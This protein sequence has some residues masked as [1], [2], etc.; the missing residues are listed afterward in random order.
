MPRGP[1]L[2]A[3]GVLH[4]VIARG[5]ERRAIFEDD[6]DRN[7][8][9]DRL[10]SIV[11]D[12][13]LLVYAWALMPNHFHL[14]VRTGSRPLERSM[15]ALLSGYATRFN[16]RHDRAGHL[17]QNRYKSIVVEEERYFLTLVRYI[18]RNP[19]GSVVDDL[20]ALASYPYTG[21]PALLGTMQ[22]DWQ[23]TAE[24]LRQFGDRDG[25]AI[26]RYLEFMG[27]DATANGA[28][29]DGGGLKRSRGVWKHVDALAKGRER[30][31]SDERVLGSSAFVERIRCE[32]RDDPR[33][34]CGLEE[35][36]S[37]VCGSLGIRPESVHSGGRTRIVSRAREGI[38]YLWTIHGGASNRALAR[39]LGLAE[40]PLHRAARRGAREASRWQTL[41]DDPKP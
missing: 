8:L 23:A 20:E 13:G 16:R 27:S 34:R 19:L 38:A 30:F 32:L 12:G 18:H 24:I 26:R 39:H 31:R 22:R 37:R 5:I 14:L 35:L 1:R 28:D 3:T 6:S 15:R 10:A 2:D 41:L 17:F 21:H 29:L 33:P 9:L 36:I 4:H 25:E 40:S 11:R 7:D